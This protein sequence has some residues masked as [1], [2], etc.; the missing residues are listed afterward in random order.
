VIRFISI[1]FITLMSFTLVACKTTE[2]LE[3][4]KG[5]TA[6]QIFTQ[7]EH[8]LAAGHYESA[9]KDFEALDTLYPFGAYSQQGQLDII[10]AYYKKGDDAESALAAADRYIRLYPRSPDVDYAYYMKGLINMG[11]NDSWI[12]RWI[13]SDPAQ[14][15]LSGMDQAF[16]DFNL[17][18]QR[19]PNSRYAP[20][21]RKRMIY[22]RNLL[23]QNQL[24]IAR[25]YLKRKA[26]VASANRASN[27]VSLYQGSPQVVPALSIMYESYRALNE[28]K[29]ANDAL[30]LLITNYPNSSEA[31]HLASSSH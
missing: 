3:I 6:E 16:Q 22:I 2:P 10:Y 17:L 31:K 12:D 24:E 4:Y 23:A 25:F 5:D 9:A 1:I 21:S 15:D 11:T 7:A 26:Y 29:M 8:N 30:R 14:R 28:D 18:V 19:F 27:V 20:D 13:R